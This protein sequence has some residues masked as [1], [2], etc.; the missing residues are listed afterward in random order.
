VAGRLVG[1]LAACQ[2][3]EWLAGWPNSWLSAERDLRADVPA[4]GVVP[5][6]ELTVVALDARLLAGWWLAGW[7]T[8]WL[9]VLLTCLLTYRPTDLS[10]YLPTYLL[11]YDLTYSRSCAIACLLACVLA[12]LRLT[13]I[14]K[15]IHTSTCIHAYL[16]T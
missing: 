16:P 12:C 6:E 7:L 9:A 15:E 1:W 11:S 8:G 14:H 13:Y 4:I 5:E 3:A 10:T 2:L